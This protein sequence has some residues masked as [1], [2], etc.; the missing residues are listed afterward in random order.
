[1]RTI[2]DHFLGSANRAP[3]AKLFS[4]ATESITYEDAALRV[5][6][7]LEVLAK[8]ELSQGDRVVCYCEQ[9]LPLAMFMLTCAAGGVIPVPIS[10]VFSISYL[11]TLARQCGARAIYATEDLRAAVSGLGAPV[12][13][14]DD[15][16]AKVE[17]GLFGPPAPGMD[18]DDA[19]AIFEGYGRPA[20]A[21]AFV[22]QPTSGSTGAP[23]LV[24][25]THAGF[26]RYAEFVGDEIAKGWKKDRPPR[27]LAANALTHAFAGHMLTTALRFGAEIL[28]PS[29]L[30]MNIRLAELRELDPD[31]LPMTPR[32]LRSLLLQYQKSS[33]EPD[34]RLYGP[35]AMLHV[36]AG[37]TG[38]VAAFRKLRTQGVEIIE[39]YG[40]SEASIV[41]V[42]PHGQWREGSAGKPVADAVIKIASSGEILV[43]SPGIMA[44]YYG[45][46]DL[47]ELMFDDENFY[48]TGDLGAIDDEGYLRILGR[49]R[50]LF[51][52]VEGT[53]IYPER[54][55]IMLESLDFVEQV[56]LVG[57]GRPYI[58][59]HIVLRHPRDR[60]VQDSIMVMLEHL[61]V[62]SDA[63][64]PEDAHSALYDR[65]GLEL[66][67]INQQLEV[68]EQIVGFALYLSPFPP[69][70]YKTLRAGKHSR[71]R[72]AFAEKFKPMID[73]LYSPTL[74]S[75]SSYLVPPRE[76]RFRPRVVMGKELEQRAMSAPVAPRGTPPASSAVVTSPMSKVPSGPVTS[77]TT[78]G[79]TAAAATMPKPVIPRPTL[80]K[81]P[82][83]SGR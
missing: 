74:D 21:D 50:D 37:G 3:Q 18:L 22:I 61:N 29:E 64:L 59:A 2:W 70:V 39:F 67:R 15:G 66:A 68:V 51:N 57:D 33:Q 28:I 20:Y 60:A 11:H 79:K 31:I 72:T 77:A 65:S 8:L 35:S 52:T 58:T 5:A 73:L 44:G 40:S 25:R 49:K 47:T 34:A 32:V 53:N 63:F 55:E 48:R 23:K 6:N 83:R 82:S 24:L 80:P 69:E 13:I 16:R 62:A 1:M 54:I 7:G 12:L 9:T 10:P 41:S 38:D 76:R 26:A 14:Y 43:T 81:P 46:R 78:V 42:T 27:I 45:E 71:D 17:D 19:N 36:T 30:D 4:T 56:F 75:N